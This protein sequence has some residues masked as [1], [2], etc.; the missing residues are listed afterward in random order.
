M[1]GVQMAK[2]FPNL[3]KSQNK[4]KPVVNF[5]CAP[6]KYENKRKS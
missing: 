6:V 4:I 3:N 1:Y 5:K 2:P